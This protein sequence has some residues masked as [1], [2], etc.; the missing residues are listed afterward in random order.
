MKS[1]IKM[2]SSEHRTPYILI[3]GAKEQEENSVTCR[4]RFSSGIQQRTFTLDGF[5]E[6]AADKISSH[7]NGI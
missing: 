2:I 1:K 3:V 4:F 6:Y 5:L 7:Y